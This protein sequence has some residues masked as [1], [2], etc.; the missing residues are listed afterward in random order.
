MSCICRSIRV[1]W[2]LD[3]VVHAFGSPTHATIRGNLLAAG[4]S[5]S[6]ADL[7]AFAIRSMV[8]H[9]GGYE[10]VEEALARYEAGVGTVRARLCATV[11]PSGRTVRFPSSALR[12]SPCVA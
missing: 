10:G 3:D 4:C 11:P 2:V 1:R 9:M 5:A 8:L 6:F 7:L 12:G